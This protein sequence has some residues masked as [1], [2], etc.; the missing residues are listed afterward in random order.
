M[1]K[2]FLNMSIHIFTSGN[3]AAASLGRDDDL[4]LLSGERICVR[5]FIR[6]CLAESKAKIIRIYGQR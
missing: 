5:R 1:P 6:V 3:V 4:H 2:G